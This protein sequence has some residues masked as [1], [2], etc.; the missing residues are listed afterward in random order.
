MKTTMASVPVVTN[1][2]KPLDTS[3]WTNHDKRNDAMTKEQREAAKNFKKSIKKKP[4]PMDMDVDAAIQESMPWKEVKSRKDNSSAVNQEN[5]SKEIAQQ[6]DV[7]DIAKSKLKKVKVTITIRVPKEIDNF[8]PAKMHIDMLHAI[9]K[10]DESAIF[11]NSTGD[12]KVNIESSLSE[13]Q[14]KD[15][16]NLVEKRVGRGPVSISISHDICV[17]CKASEIK[18]AIFPYL[19][20]NKIFIYFN[21]KPGLEHFSAIGVL[22]GP[23]P[24]FTW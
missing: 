11:F 19:K 16:F 10:H 1:I 21:P 24:D 7:E 4:S 9:H 22:F 18:E 20:K 13:K 23:N 6:E 12:K 15:S 17:T 14:Y 5:E 8:S 2:T 3:N